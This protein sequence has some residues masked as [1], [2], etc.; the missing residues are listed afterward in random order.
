MRVRESERSGD[1]MRAGRRIGRGTVVG[2]L[3]ALSVLQVELVSVRDDARLARARQPDH[4]D[5]DARLDEVA[6]AHKMQ[7]A[8]REGAHAGEAVGVA[9][10]NGRFASEPEWKRRPREEQS[11]RGCG[12]HYEGSYVRR[13]SAILPS[14]VPDK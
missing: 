6:V 10:P 14:E 8:V 2:A 7:R 3:L 1:E 4:E 13:S 9:A 5:G 11:E 12:S